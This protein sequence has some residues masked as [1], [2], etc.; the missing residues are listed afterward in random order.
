M[1]RPPSSKPLVA[2]ISTVLLVPNTGP[3][4]RD[5]KESNIPIGKHFTDLP[6]PGAIALLQQPAGLLTAVLGDITATRFQRRGVRGVVANGRVRDIGP[7]GKLCSSETTQ[8]EDGSQMP[9]AVWSKGTST[10]GPALECRPWCT[11][12]PIIIGQLE[13]KPGDYVFADETE[14]GIVVIPQEKAEQVVQLLP[15]FKDRDDLRV[16]DVQAGM[17]ISESN[18]RRL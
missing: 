3:L 1:L 9:F 8:A 2:P 18:K 4:D 13:V 12:I 14:R 17:S 6:A 5:P 7:T 15:G 11:D 10:V 16:A